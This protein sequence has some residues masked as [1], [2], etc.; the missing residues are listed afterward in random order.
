MGDT[1]TLYVGD[2]VPEYRSPREITFHMVTPSPFMWVMG[3][4]NTGAPVRT[5]LVGDG[6]TKYR[7]PEQPQ[8][9][10]PE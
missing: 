1:I 7:N 3:Y 9:G 6:V 10:L 4:L 5:P 8:C 2:G